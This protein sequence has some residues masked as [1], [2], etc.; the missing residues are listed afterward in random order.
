MGRHC[1]IWEDNIANNNIQEMGYDNANSKAIAS[2]G[3][4][5]RRNFDNNGYVTNNGFH[6]KTDLLRSAQ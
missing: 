1:I 4:D 2:S 5:K 6:T 3:R